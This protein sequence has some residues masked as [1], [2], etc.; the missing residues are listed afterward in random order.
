M[1]NKSESSPHFVKGR[2]REGFYP[3]V[4]GSVWAT[5]LPFTVNCL[6]FFTPNVAFVTIGM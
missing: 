4:K 1:T 6:F 5:V 2:V 3:K